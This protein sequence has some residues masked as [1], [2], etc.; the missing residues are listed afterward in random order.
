MR[1][2]D[3]FT[4]AGGIVEEGVLAG[5]VYDKYGSRNPIV[6]MLM[7]GFEEA[8]E[9]LVTRAQPR[10]IHEVGCGEGRWIIDWATRGIEA[11]GSDFS[12]QIIALAERNAERHGANARFRAASIYDLEPS[13][14]AAELVVCC[15]VLEHLDEPRTQLH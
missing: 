14:D 7:K 5:N 9:G 2:L 3:S 15:E 10:S 6:R 4:I 12:S 11:R 1:K 8:L 13:L